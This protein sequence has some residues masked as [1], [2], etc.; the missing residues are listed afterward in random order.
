MADAAA[1]APAPAPAA[2]PL[3]PGSF[4]HGLPLSGVPTPMP[5]STPGDALGL[6]PQFRGLPETGAGASAAAAAAP[7][8]PEV[9]AF[10]GAGHALSSG[11]PA[12]ASELCQPRTTP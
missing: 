10:S 7:A 11:V 3:K 5:T 9:E 12:A 1:R 8:K 4:I 6:G 2:V